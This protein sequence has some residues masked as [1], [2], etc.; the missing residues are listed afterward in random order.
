MN[1]LGACPSNK[2]RKTVIPE[3]NTSLER[4]LES[5]NGPIILKNTEK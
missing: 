2:A 5:M 1:K 3:M 4:V